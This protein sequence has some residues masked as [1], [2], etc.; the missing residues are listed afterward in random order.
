MIIGFQEIVE[1]NTSSV[2]LGK[3]NA[4]NVKIWNDQVLSDMNRLGDERYVFVTGESLVGV[5]IGLFAK[6]TIS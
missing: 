1:L 3:S 6:K 4:S 2:L 5:Y